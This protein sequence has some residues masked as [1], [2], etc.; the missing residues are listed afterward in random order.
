VVVDEVSFSST[1]TSRLSVSCSERMFM[2]ETR[3]GMTWDRA[4]EVF[5]RIKSKDDNRPEISTDE[6]SNR[7]HID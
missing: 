2:W 4:L 7:A 3:V 1:S 6:A 5:E